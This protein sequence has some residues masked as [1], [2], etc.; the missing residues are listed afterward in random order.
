MK[1]ELRT[2]L[3][4]AGIAC[5][6]T[7]C[8]HN[9]ETAVDITRP[10]NLHLAPA[11][12]VTVDTRAAVGATSFDNNDQVGIFQ[13]WTSGATGA[14]PIGNAIV[15]N[16][17]W[18]NG[19][20]TGG[21]SLYWQNTADVHTFYAYYPY[22]A[23]L[24]G[25][26]KSITLSATQTADTYEQNDVMWGSTSTKA[27]NSV[28]IKMGHKLSQLVINLAKGD[29]FENGTLP[30]IKSV[31]IHCA[32]GLIPGGT[33]NIGTGDVTATEAT[34]TSTDLTTYAHTDGKYYAIVMPTQQFTGNDYVRIIT[35]D[36]TTYTY[37]L[38]SSAF[39]TESN[40]TYSINLTLNKGGITLSG[41]SIDPWST[42]ETTIEGDADMDLPSTSGNNA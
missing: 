29:G 21:E 23:N 17:C 1:R 36:G 3:C 22:D 2:M 39:T 16:A 6:A 34:S 14:T 13:A 9:E 24:T 35:E 5:L 11:P 20:I 10:I 32:Q 33:L 25:T 28:S 27:Q 31:S 4:A 42:S 18:T 41:L 40:F 30:T 19:S 12:T 26:T 38:N 8:T 7:A 15:S 37:T